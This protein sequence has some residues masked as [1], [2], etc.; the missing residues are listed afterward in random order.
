MSNVRKYHFH[1]FV[2]HSLY[3]QLFAL[4][5]FVSLM[6]LNETCSRIRLGKYLSEIFPSKDG[7]KKEMIYRYFFL[8][9]LYIMPLGGFR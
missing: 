4:F 6:R 5:S 9:L 3:G 8:N 1:K 7:L 2:L